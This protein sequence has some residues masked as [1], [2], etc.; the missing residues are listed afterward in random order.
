[1]KKVFS[2]SLLLLTSCQPTS[3]ISFLGREDRCITILTSNEK[4]YKSTDIINVEIISNTLDDTATIQSIKI[5]PGFK[6][7]ITQINVS[8]NPKIQLCFKRYRATKGEVQVRYY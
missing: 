1:M 8:Y 5:Y 2:I 6:G 7:V 3:T 4:Q